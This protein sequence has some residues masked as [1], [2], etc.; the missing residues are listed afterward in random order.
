M[1]A[2]ARGRVR[3]VRVVLGHILS[4]ILWRLR[5]EAHLLSRRVLRRLIQ[6]SAHR[7]LRKQAQQVAAARVVQRVWAVLRD[8]E[9]AM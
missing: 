5:R 4:S 8:R 2:R 3:A 7:L 9:R 6:R 1:A